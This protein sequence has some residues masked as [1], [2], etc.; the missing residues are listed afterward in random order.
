[1]ASLIERQNFVRRMTLNDH[2]RVTIN[3]PMVRPGSEQNSPPNSDAQA[4]PN[5]IPK[6]TACQG[7][8]KR[9]AAQRP[10]MMRTPGTWLRVR[11]REA[12]TQTSSAH[13]HVLMFARHGE[14]V[15]DVT[16]S[17]PTLSP[18]PV[19]VRSR[20]W[21]QYVW[22]VDDEWIL[23]YLRSMLFIIGLR[24]IFFFLSAHTK[25]ATPSPPTYM[26]KLPTSLI[27]KTLSTADSR[28][29][30]ASTTDVPPPSKVEAPP[31]QVTKECQHRVTAEGC[32]LDATST[33]PHADDAQPTTT[34]HPLVGDSVLVHADD[35]ENEEEPRESESECAEEDNSRKP[36][37][38]D[39]HSPFAA[40]PRVEADENV[41][42]IAAAGD[43]GAAEA[44]T[45]HGSELQVIE[46]ETPS[47]DIPGA[48]DDM[49]RLTV[50]D[51]K[52]QLHREGKSTKGSKTELLERVRK[53]SVRPDD[54]IVLQG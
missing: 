41:V 48:L 33:A 35:A 22:C 52:R 2:K 12:M 7:G 19:A 23:P 14:R 49:Y 51:L 8:T 4:R 11:R 24:A 20:G 46:F 42:G 31:V 44:L 27:S 47:P 50:K 43:G 10:T 1:M 6:K 13:A 26:F 38:N 3:P 29:S 54:D 39:A 9:Y 37:T 17:V 15:N 40:V 36:E 30:C 45:A 32:T 18:P 28:D 25:A 53:M 21:S 34:A 16:H 5:R